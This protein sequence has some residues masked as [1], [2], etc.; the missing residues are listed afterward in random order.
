MSDPISRRHA[1]GSVTPDQAPAPEPT[2]AE[3]ARTLIHL[4]RVGALSTMSRKLAGY[5][6]GSVMPYALDDAGRPVFLISSMAMHTQNLV[7]DPRASL[8]VT[9]TENADPLGSARLTLMGEVSKLS[10]EEVIA[11]RPIYLA[12]HETARYWVDYDDFA[13][14]RMGIADVYFVGGFGVMGWVTAQDYIEA[15]AD[16]LAEAAPGIL[17]HMN[18]DHADA[19]LLLAKFFAGAEADQATMTSVD[20]LGF[21]LRLKTA[22]RVRGIRVAFLVQARSVADTRKIMEQMLRLARESV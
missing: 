8:L 13:F 14:Y 20:R 3:R 22:D 2:Y 7:G 17:E 21:H 9:Q 15:E 5:P 10:A 4:G 1:S 11:I 6:F 19:L 18:K 12:R 16:P